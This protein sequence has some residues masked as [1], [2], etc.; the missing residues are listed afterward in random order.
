M[1]IYTIGGVENMSKTREQF[2]RELAKTISDDQMTKILQKTGDPAIECII[3]FALKIMQDRN[4]MKT[5]IT[6]LF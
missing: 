1:L 3:E 4:E 6:K 2:M 5:L